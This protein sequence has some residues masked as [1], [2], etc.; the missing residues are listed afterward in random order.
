MLQLFFLQIEIVGM[1]S[2]SIISVS[3]SLVT[4]LGMYKPLAASALISNKLAVT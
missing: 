4:K 1:R 2:I 3:G